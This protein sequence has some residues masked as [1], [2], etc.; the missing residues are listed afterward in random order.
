MY[1]VTLNE[2]MAVLRVSAQPGP[3]GAV[4]TTSVESTAQEDD[5][6]EVK[7]RERYISDNVSQTAKK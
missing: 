4:N 6:Q 2:L 7:R 1:A 3:S 5:F